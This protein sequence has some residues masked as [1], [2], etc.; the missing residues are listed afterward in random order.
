MLEVVPL[1]QLAAHIGAHGCHVRGIHQQ[2]VFEVGACHLACRTVDIDG[3][4]LHVERDQ[5]LG[6]AVVVVAEVDGSNSA[7]RS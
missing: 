4:E 1:W 7:G 2:P 6:V 3:V 5:A